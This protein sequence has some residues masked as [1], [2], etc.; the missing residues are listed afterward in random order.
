MDYTESMLDHT[1]PAPVATEDIATRMNMHINDDPRVVVYDIETDNSQG[2]GLDPYRSSITQVAVSDPA[3]TVVLD[4]Q[5]LDEVY[6]LE[7]I[8]RLFD[9]VAREDLVLGGWNNFGFDNSFVAVRMV[10]NKDALRAL[11][12]QV[13]DSV[14][15]MLEPVPTLKAK[16]DVAG[17]FEHPQKIRWQGKTLEQF[18]V[19]YDFQQ[20]AADNGVKHSLKP[21][22][23]HLGV[24]ILDVD[25]TR[26]HDYDL[27]TRT[28]YAAG[29]TV[30]TL[31]LRQES[32]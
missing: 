11:G 6:I 26:L 7:G 25:R 27:E 2:F 32:A 24:R 4:S 20:Y 21:V 22:A 23:E 15:E 30:M 13:P 17:G 19:S 28:A 5:T 12:V 8:A 3:S 16:Y 10:A 31:F 1:A 29:D 9:L 14:E 18:D